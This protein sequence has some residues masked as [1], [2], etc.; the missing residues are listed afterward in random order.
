[1][2]K[3]ADFARGYQLGSQMVK[4]YRA[5][6]DRKDIEQ[7]AKATP[8]K[9]EGF[10]ADQGEQLRLAAESG[11]YDVGFD[12]DAKAYTVTPKVGGESGMIR[13]GA[14]TEFRGTR[15]AGDLSP[16]QID[17]LRGNAIADVMMRA[18]PAR[19]LQFRQQIQQGERAEE[20]FG[21][22]KTEFGNRQADRAEQD[23]IKAGRRT[24]YKELTGIKDPNELAE[25][26]GGA[27]SADGSGVD[28]MLTFDPSANK[29]VFA[30]KVPGMPSRTLDRAE[31]VNMAMGVWEQGNGDFDRGMQRLLEGVREQR[32]L[33]ERDFD[34]SATVAQGNAGLHWKQQGH[35]LDER[36][37]GIEQQ[38]A[39][40]TGAYYR[41]L[42]NRANGQG[43]ATAEG[44]A[45]QNKVDGV[46]EGYQAAMSTGNKEAAAIYAREYDQLRA[47]TPKGLRTLPSL[48][49]LNNAQRGGDG[50]P[51]KVEDPGTAYLVN[52]QL[53]YTDGRGG[54]VSE[55]GVMPQ[56]RGSFLAESGVPAPLIGK[57]PW[58]RDGT[59]VL[60]GGMAYDV[61]DPQ[62]MRELSR[63]YRELGAATKEV[64][65]YQ[66]ATANPPR[67]PQG[68]GIAVPEVPSILD[69][70]Q[71][72]E[73]NRNLGN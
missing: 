11:Q 51:V 37:L 57:L 15:V 35:D 68:L 66:R 40:Q 69:S 33:G 50:K 46:L 3:W 23:Q 13:P 49:A 62:D 58:N 10:T 60:F 14:V 44:V 20:D 12:Q 61:R 30:S 25:R 2:A 56:E 24:Y 71:M 17:A 64:E 7:I 42:A 27:F 9:F 21:M 5:E 54:Y 1:M 26:L 39:N 55:G 22:R 47:L 31:L 32:R 41:A 67:R 29:F 59:S 18:D 6:K 34:R 53:K 36:K 16:R 4:D 52:G 70:M 43:A 45:F 48:Q 8:D 63:R 72:Y 73:R 65:E 19:G 28:A 38:K